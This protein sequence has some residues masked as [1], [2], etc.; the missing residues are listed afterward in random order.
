MAKPNQI[1]IDFTHLGMNGEIALEAAIEGALH[2]VTIDAAN[3]DIVA[4]NARR[5][6]LAIRRQIHKQNSDFF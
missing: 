1:V 4:K 6:L 3:G 2:D 5:A